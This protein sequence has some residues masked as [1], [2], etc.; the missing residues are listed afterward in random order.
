MCELGITLLIHGKAAEQALSAL[1]AARV[2][3]SSKV[4]YFYIS[5][6]ELWI[7]SLF[8]CRSHSTRTEV[9]AFQIVGNFLSRI[10]EK[11]VSLVNI[12]LSLV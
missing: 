1:V 4:G 12:G 9:P 10:N 2:C 11:V 7:V 6:E 5:T 8:P 3:V